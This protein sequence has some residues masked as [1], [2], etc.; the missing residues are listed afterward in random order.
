MQRWI[1]GYCRLLDAVSAG[2]LL[3]MVVLVFGNVVLRYGFNSGWTVSEE[4]SRWAFIWVVFL[5][6]IV[7]VRERGHLGT[8][9]LISRLPRAGQR[10]CYAVSHLLMLLAAWLVLQGSWA[11]VLIN[12]DVSAPTTGWSMGVVYLSGV[13]FAASTCV[14][15]VL[16]L[17]RL[18]T[19]GVPDAELAALPETEEKAHTPSH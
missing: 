8:D 9:L 5:G 1:H 14:L 18:L 3:I 13:V 17:L 6:S 19:G 16:N 4:V 12:W 7:A 11:Q 10:V 15:L 2:L